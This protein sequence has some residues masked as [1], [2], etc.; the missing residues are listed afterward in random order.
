MLDLTAA[1]PRYRVEF[2]ARA[3]ASARRVEGPIGLDGLW[4]SGDGGAGGDGELLAVK[5]RWLAEDTF[6]IVSRAV[7]EGIIR[8]RGIDATVAAN[9]GYTLRLRGRQS[10]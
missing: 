6:Q 8:G 7:T 9:Q 10:E 3:G 2:E 4:R 5:G 1:E